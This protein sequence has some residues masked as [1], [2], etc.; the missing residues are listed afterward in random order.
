MSAARTLKSVFLVAKEAAMISQN[1]LLLFI[2]SSISQVKQHYVLISLICR[3]NCI[4]LHPNEH[5]NTFTGKD[6]SKLGSFLVI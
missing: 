4:P 3:L 5:S 1:K 2:S 6:M